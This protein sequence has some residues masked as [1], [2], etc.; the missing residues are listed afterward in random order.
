M[1]KSEF[2]YRTKAFAINI[3]TFCKTLPYDFIKDY[4]AQLIR[5]SS[6]VAANYRSACRAKSKADFVNKMRIVEEEPDE[7]MLFLEL[8]FELYQKKREEIKILHNK[9]NELLSMTVSSI[10][11]VLKSSEKST[12]ANRQSKF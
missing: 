9:A 6:S 3:E 4:I 11:T 1:D 8:I 2:Q 5:S 7:S 10:N 12:I